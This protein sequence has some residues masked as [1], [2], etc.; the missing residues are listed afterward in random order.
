VDI[1]G[2]VGCSVDI[3]GGVGCSVDISGG[4]GCSVDIS[5]GV[6]C[7]ADISGG[8]RG[9]TG[10]EGQKG[11]RKVGRARRCAGSIFGSSSCRVGLF[12]FCRYSRLFS[13]H[14]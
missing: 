5:G 1:S 8:V 14:I 12:L 10:W 4:V 3:S 13:L 9:R 6:G 11:A 7:S 2:G